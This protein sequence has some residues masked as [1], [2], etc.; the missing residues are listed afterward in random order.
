VLAVW[1]QGIFGGGRGEWYKKRGL[2]ILA[3]GS[4]MG[5]LEKPKS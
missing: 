4:A 1:A 2:R 5:I 3:K